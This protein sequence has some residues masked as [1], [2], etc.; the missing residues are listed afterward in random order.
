MPT[1][2]Q[3]RK[4]DPI[5]IQKPA[6]PKTTH[7]KTT[8]SSTLSNTGTN[9]AASPSVEVDVPK[10]HT[11]TVPFGSTSSKKKP[12][13]SKSKSRADGKT[14]SSTTINNLIQQNPLRPGRPWTNT[15]GSLPD[16][17][18]IY[19]SA[20]KTTTSKPSKQTSKFSK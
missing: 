14:S 3:K 20:L 7:W 5:S 17:E 8:S 2:S 18:F 4:V 19:D 12:K 1:P 13:K 16:A 15:Y 10:L 11:P 6:S 9:R